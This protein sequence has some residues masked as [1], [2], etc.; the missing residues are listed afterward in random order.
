MAYADDA[1]GLQFE[2]WAST[3]G[4]PYALKTT[5]SAISANITDLPPNSAVQLKMRGTSDSGNTYTAFTPVVSLGT[6]AAMTTPVLEATRN[7]S[8]SIAQ[9]NDIAV[10]ASLRVVVGSGNL[11]IS[12]AG[13]I[14]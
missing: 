5:V 14:M 2:V 6:V 8:Y 13:P 1:A 9:D 4:S 10:N 12:S 7:T 11:N 3:S